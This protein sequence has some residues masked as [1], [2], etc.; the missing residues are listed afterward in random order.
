MGGGGGG[1]GGAGSAVSQIHV[2]VVF[3][4]KVVE[5]K[6]QPKKQVNKKCSTLRECLWCVWVCVCVLD[7]KG[8]WVY[9]SS[10]CKHR[11]L[12]V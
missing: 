7:R 1:G 12:C 2:L 9:S 11:Q 4:G 6:Q 5:D 8:T 10:S 3:V